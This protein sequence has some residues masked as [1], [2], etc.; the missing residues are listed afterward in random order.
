MTSELELGGAGT[1]LVT[2]FRADGEVDLEAFRALVQRQVAAGISLLVPCGT[3]GE[4][5]TL[6]DDEREVL[7]RVCVAEARGGARVVAGTGSNDTRAA[8]AS[9]RAAA[10]WGADA[11]L[12]LA[13]PYNK[14]PQDALV[15]HFTA[16][17][18][19]AGVPVVVYNVP[20]R[21]GCNLTARTTL[22]LA[23]VPGIAAVKEA[24][25]DMA[26][27]LRILRDR[28]RGFSFLSGEDALTLPFLALGAEGCISVVGNEAPR[29]L[30]SLVAA[31]R[32]GSTVVARALH[33]RLL[34]LMEANF[35]ESNPIPVKAALA[36]RGV[37][38]NELRLPLVEMDASALARLEAA[39]RREELL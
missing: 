17:A 3:T 21:T 37:I 27:C 8:V 9:A 4:S 12:S 32:A 29:D 11:V 35:V 26:Q 15:A 36:L 38:A 20:G 7:V 13:P 22:E 31:A 16:V 28:P 33:E 18:E 5:A 19:G 10:E 25:A 14:P 6:S 23:H 24:S 39:L 30:A 1:A 34:P 2:P